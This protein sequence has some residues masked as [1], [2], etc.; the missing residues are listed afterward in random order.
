MKRLHLT[1]IFLLLSFVFLSKAL[2][3]EKRLALVIGNNDY[4]FGGSLDN[5]ANDARSMEEALKLVGFDVIKYEN[6]D[7]RMMRQ[8][9]DNFGVLLKNYDVGLFFYAGH[10]IQAK[11]FNYL[12]PVD[13]ALASE[14][15]VEYNCVRADRVLGKMEAAA[16][17]TNIVILDACRNN[18]FER[19]WTRSPTGKGLAFMNAPTGSLIA[20][21]TSPGNTASDGSGSNGLYTSALLSYIV[22]P[23]ITAIQMF[24]LVRTFV[25]EK[26]SGQQVP[27]ESTS[28]EGDFYFNSGDSIQTIYTGNII[29]P[30]IITDNNWEASSGTF[31]DLRDDQEYD[32]V[33]IG[34][35]IWMSE[36]LNY[37]T[38]SGSWCY[39]NIESNCNTYGRLYN[40]ETARKICPDG[41]HL[42]SDEEWKEL[43]KHVE[44]INAGGKLKETGSLHWGR[45]NKGATNEIGFTALPGGARDYSGVFYN[46]ANNGFWWSSTEYS[47]TDARNRCMYRYGDTVGRNY[48]SKEYGFSVR[49]IKDQ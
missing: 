42:S 18:P 48:Y 14:A 31:I 22:D 41:W 25:R 2:A 16:N 43:E 12:I 9:I 4:Q 44:G 30:E 45:P 7:Q 26:S 37:Q 27:W 29:S 28:L 11:G 35:Q 24:Q 47:S 46:I 38:V 5:P 34:D 15:D 33:K 39:K 10:G 17:K 13:A 20:Y 6:L 40:W 21:A 32:W 1:F 19:S 49:C 3:Q 36:N 8:A 23:N